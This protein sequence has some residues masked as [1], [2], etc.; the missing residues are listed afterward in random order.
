MV[1][2]EERWSEALP[3]LPLARVLL[4]LGEADEAERRVAEV[5]RS[6]PGELDAL[7]L[8][9][10][11]KHVRGELSQAIAC[12]AELYARAPLAGTAALYLRSLLQLAMDPERGAGAFV[13]I[14]R[15]ELGRAPLAHLEL[16][17]AFG[18]LVA[19]HPR[20]AVARAEAVAREYRHRD[21]ETFKLAVLAAAWIAELSGE[22]ERACRILEQLGEERT[23]AT[24]VDR[25]LAL[26]RLY[27]LIGTPARLE[28][29]VHVCLYL[30]GRHP[31]VDVLGDL[32]QLFA[33]LGDRAH[34][35]RFARE[36][37]E[38]FR[39]RMHRPSRLE[40]IRVAARRYL[41]LAK[42][43]RLSLPEEA[44]P[45]L[46]PREHA[47]ADVL[48]GDRLGARA[49]FEHLGTALDRRYLA[50][51]ALLSGDPDAA[52]ALLLELLAADP[53]ELSTLG[54]LL[55]LV[56]AE[57]APR[58]KALLARPELANAARAAL[59]R[60]VRAEPH[61]P[62]PWRRLATLLSSIPGEEEEARLCEARAHAH[63]AAARLKD[64]PVGRVLAAAVYHF[65]ARKKGL[66]HEVWAER[67]PA[68]PGL[69]GTLP[70]EQILGNLSTELQRN[71]QSI[72]LSV[73]EYAQIKLPHLTQDLFDHRY[74]YKVTKDDET[75]HGVSA[76][77]PTAL[78]FLSVFLQRPV[79]Q[80]VASSGMLVTDA[81]D[82]LSVRPVGDVEHKVK[83]AVNRNLRSIL[84][85]R[86][87]RP[88]LV[89]SGRIPAGIL[90]E[91]V[92]FVGSLDEA[93]RE[94]FGD[95][96]F[97]LPSLRARET[98]RE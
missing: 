95:E 85:P 86:G 88:E 40:V 7:A 6:A 14:G 8:Y 33:R 20:E 19:R 64:R 58:A 4:E 27:Q 67:E 51:L 44:L 38:A 22:L 37:S 43:S 24:D 23:F 97:A 96:L 48:R 81:R 66:I 55:D 30:R 94:V 93:V 35:D 11:V 16:T 56:G 1:T 89:A 49:S 32:A 50:E 15:G 29:A 2:S 45:E 83:G 41:P 47:L 62:A 68:L 77:L 54:A 17:E 98:E 12:W 61:Q 52:V 13:A 65:V 25:V 28:A 80:D 92:T 26:V 31:S 71:V 76:G 90:E 79:P 84:L 73:R 34:A 69:G 42:L 39:R 63:E 21:R 91:T 10:K 70:R 60:A 82:V 72:F 87:N 78:A 75:S 57:V 46:E 5:L 59:E 74:T 9:A 36:H 3:P 53:E 18:L